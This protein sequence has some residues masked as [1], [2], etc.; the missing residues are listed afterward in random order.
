MGYLGRRIGKSQ[1]QGDSSPEAANGAVGGGILDLF[2]NGYFERQG[3]I[4]NAPG[5]REA[6]VVATGGVI[7]DYTDNGIVYR[8]HVFTST[9]ELDVTGTGTLGAQADFLV[10]GGGGAGGSD[11]GNNGAAG[12][13]GAGGYRSTMPEGPGGPSPSAES[14]LTLTVQPYTITVGGG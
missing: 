13:G 10:V 14:Q 2:S 11:P 7:S 1:N 5:I 8:A 6:G 4:Y 3:N 9:G 12:G